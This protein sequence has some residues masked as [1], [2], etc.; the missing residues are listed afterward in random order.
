MIIDHEVKELIQQFVAS[1]HLQFDCASKFLRQAL[2][3]RGALL[4]GPPGTGKTYLS[5][6]V[7]T[8]S[9]SRML[10][11]DYA[12]LISDITARSEKKIKAAFTLASKLYPCVLFIDEVDSLFCRR[13]SDEKSWERAQTNQFLQEMDGLLENDKAP[14]V[15][16]ATNRPWDLDEAFLGRLQHKVYLGL[17]DTEARARLLEL[18]LH[19]D[20]LDPTVNINGL[21]QV[22]EK[23]SGSDIK[24]LCA[25]AGLLWEA[26]RARL[27]TLYR[28]VS[29]K[30][31]KANKAQKKVRLRIDHFVKALNEIQPSNSK[32]LAER[33]ETFAREHNPTAFISGRVS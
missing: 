17:P 30:F 29:N 32:D 4:Y 28:S 13:S 11:V 1:H 18:F 22:T 15:L 31:A 27:H 10:A 24:T 20:D 9:G 8:A 5:R 26:E 14:L 33:H 25:K 16:V 7:G 3:I 19:Q 23:Y 2:R 12:S 21:A 6:A